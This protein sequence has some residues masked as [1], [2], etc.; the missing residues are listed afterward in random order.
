MEKR[1]LMELAGMQDPD[2]SGR[3]AEMGGEMDGEMGAGESNPVDTVTVDIPL[4]IRLLEWAKEDSQNDMQLHKVAENLTNLSQEGESL[5]MESYEDAIAGV[6]EMA[7]G[8]EEPAM[9]DQ[10]DMQGMR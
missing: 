6:E 4:F 3:D 2:Y 9:G 1:R 7:G 8:E 5:S 10:T